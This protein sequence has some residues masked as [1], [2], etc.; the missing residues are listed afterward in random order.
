LLYLFEQGDFFGSED[1]VR[2]GRIHMCADDGR[3]LGFLGLR[4][5]GCHTEGY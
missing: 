4:F 2:K 3:Q 1:K 5:S